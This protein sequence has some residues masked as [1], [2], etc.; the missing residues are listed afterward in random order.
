MNLSGANMPV[1]ELEGLLPAVGIVLPA[2][3]SL[4]S[5]AASANLNADGPADRLV[6]T[7]TIA[8][9]NA[10]LAGFDMGRKMST[11]EKLAG[12]KSGPETEIQTFRA[13]VHYAPDG[14]TIQNLK[15]VAT[16]IGDINGSG[17]ISPQDALNFKMTAVVHATGL[18]VVMGNAP[19]PF[20]INGTASD[21]QFHPDVTG[22]ATGAIK[23]VGSDAGKAATGIL[24]GIL[25]GKKP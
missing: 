17:T 6:T 23:G 9:S 20:T 25:G 18:A 2:G 7:G 1:T 12:I 11:I 16:G 5:G 8:L 21:P 10:K 3:S 22:I 14:A 24:K 15:L 4:Q 19:I 13:D